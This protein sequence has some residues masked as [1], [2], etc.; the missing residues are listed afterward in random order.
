VRQL[1]DLPGGKQAA[2]ARLSAFLG[3]VEDPERRARVEEAI[4]GVGESAFP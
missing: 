4:K 3:Q 2:A 1:L